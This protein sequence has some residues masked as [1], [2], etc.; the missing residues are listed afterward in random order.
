MG[1][2]FIPVGWIAFIFFFFPKIET[3]EVFIKKHIARQFLEAFMQEPSE[4]YNI[5]RD[6]YPSRVKPKIKLTG[7]GSNKGHFFN[8][9]TVSLV[10]SSILAFPMEIYLRDSTFTW[11]KYKSGKYYELTVKNSNWQRTRNR[12]KIKSDRSNLNVVHV[13][14]PLFAKK[15]GRI[16]I[17]REMLQFN[18][19]NKITAICIDCTSSFDDLRKKASGYGD[20]HGVDVFS[21][22]D[23]DNAFGYGD[24]RG[25]DVFSDQDE[26]DPFRGN[27]KQLISPPHPDT[28]K[29]KELDH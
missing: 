6:Y 25:V 22:Q 24:G 11:R 27:D 26:D 17:R 10:D 16:Q 20:G 13:R 4:E 3:S 12:M 23:E 2:A 28:T 15:D 7:I 8:L 18:D 19:E 1:L 21:D 14:M 9:D 29:I 5:H